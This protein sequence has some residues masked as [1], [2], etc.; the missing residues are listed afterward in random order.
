MAI[1][2]YPYP[3]FQPSMRII[4]AITNAFPASVTTTFAHQYVTGT[5][6]RLDIPTGFGM[7]QANQLF[8]P[9]EV[10][11]PTTF[12]IALDTTTF[13]VFS[14]PTYTLLPSMVVVSQQSATS[15][16]IGE[17]NNQLTAAVQNVL[18]YPAT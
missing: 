1:L 8:G 2:A 11:S 13:D 3:T 9:I 7:V 4:A 15:V 10:T 12:T 17:I 5:I 18:P 6:V 14:I 16:P